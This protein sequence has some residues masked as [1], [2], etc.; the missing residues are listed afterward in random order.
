VSAR[1]RDVE[2]RVTPVELFFDLVFVFGLTQVTAMLSED[3]TWP[4]LGRA[5][6]VLAVL[7]WIWVS[8]AW[9]TN[10]VDADDGL[11][12]ALMLFATGA[13]FMAALAVPEAF[14]PDALLFGVAVVT[15][16][17]MHLAL[18]VITARRDRPLLAAVL[19]IAP[20]GMIGALLIFSAA[21]VPARWR[22]LTM[23]IA[24]LIGLLAPLLGGMSG[25]RIRPA[26]FAERY[27]LVIIIALGESLVA[28][29][30][31]ART[32]GLGAGVITAAVLGFTVAVSFWLAYFDF[33]STAV[34]RLIAERSGGQQIALAR[35]IY[36]YLHL[37]M[38]AGVVLFAYGARVAL[39]DVGA[40][41]SWIA[42]LGL[43]GGSALYL[44][45]FVG[46][47]LRV[48]RTLSRG[49]SVAALTLLV[50]LSVATL[51]P[52]LTALGL[53]AAV[54]FA[55]HSYELIWWREARARRRATR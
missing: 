52:A 28:I 53:V 40:H 54:W 3:A 7:W 45:S 18:S 16:R 37:P 51:L 6:V 22:P 4:G 20:I 32:T 48:T 11:A 25:L 26:H 33:S 9:L 44:L 31:G 34:E 43:C 19:R 36:T 13:I 39:E 24:V 23:L 50:L 49:R 15:V 12:L 2:H 1:G 14:G 17:T 30:I 41:L 8:F 46:I 21:F 35:D 47:R 29:G 55:L 5:M 10:M 42:A 38:V 27:A